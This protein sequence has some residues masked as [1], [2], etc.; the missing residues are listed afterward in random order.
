MSLQAAKRAAE[1]NLRLID[2]SADPINYNINEILLHIV[3]ALNHLD[4]EISQLRK[5]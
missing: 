2:Q 3:E 1:E 5:R 4:L